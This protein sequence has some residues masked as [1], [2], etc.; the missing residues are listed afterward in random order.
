MKKKKK[1]KKKEKK[2]KRIKRYSAFIS[3]ASGFEFLVFQDYSGKVY[4]T[5]NYACY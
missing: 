4:P 5:G 1:K 2:K 3:A